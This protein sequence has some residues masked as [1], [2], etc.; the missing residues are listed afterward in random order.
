MSLVTLMRLTLLELWRQRIALAP[1]AVLIFLVFTGL[2]PTPEVA[3]NE[4]PFRLS[5]SEV[6]GTVFKVLQ[7][8]GV[9]VA[10]VV[11]AGLVASEVERGTVLLLATKP[12]PRWL[13]VVGKGLGAFAFLLV[14][15]ALWGVVLATII[16]LRIDANA[17][18]TTLLGTLI[19]VLPAWLFAAIALA[20]STRL[21]ALAAMAAG[22]FT[23]ILASVAP[24]MVALK[25]MASYRF[26]GQTAEVVTW[27][28]PSAQLDGLSKALT[29][30]PAP[31]WQDLAA[32][33]AI[34]AW[35][36][37]AALL[38]QRRSLS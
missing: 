9:V 29:F 14:V 10:L 11:G 32:L 37:L 6:A 31:V 34:P 18:G 2:L 25:E 38:F 23:W 24:N 8:F 12:V 33:V 1:L 3:V 7:F 13:L 5:A 16:G 17:V 26:I 15:F 22:L 35:L 30:G 4:E 36:V 21:P 20:Y 28:L 27:I 19:G